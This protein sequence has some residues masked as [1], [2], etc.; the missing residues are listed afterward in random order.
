[1]VIDLAH[2]LDRAGALRNE[3]DD[4]PQQ[5]RLAAAGRAD[6]AEDFAPPDIKRQVIEH[7]ALAK[8]DDEVA[9]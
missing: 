7:D 3:T 9:H 4:G 6:K 2:D 1:M 8:A 5:D